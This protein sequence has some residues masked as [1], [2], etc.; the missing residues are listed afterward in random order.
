MKREALHMGNIS[1]RY[2]IVG[3][4]ESERSKNSG[5]TPL[6]LALDAARAAIADAGLE[7]REIDGFMSYSENDSC[8]S[9]QLATYL[10]V[11]PKYVKDIQGGGSS[12]EMLIGDA[13]G[14]IEAGIVNT[15]LIYRAM[16]GRS[17][18]R[19]G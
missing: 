16:N 19:M 4:G 17:G 5:R 2:A 12:T 18:V 15:V 13:I 7:A 6:H 1:N 8:T 14:L 9:H 3:V 11:R 10:G